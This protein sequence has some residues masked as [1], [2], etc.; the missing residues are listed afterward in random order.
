MMS[1]MLMFLPSWGR[2]KW[3]ARVLSAGHGDLPVMGS[4]MR[5]L[6]VGGHHL[7]SFGPAGAHGRVALEEE[8]AKLGP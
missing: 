6:C 7:L 5:W 3:L 8:L 4:D 2:R 1:L